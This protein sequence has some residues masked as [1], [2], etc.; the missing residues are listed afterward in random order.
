MHVK[1]VKRNARTVC[2]PIPNYSLAFLIPTYTYMK[3]TGAKM[4]P[5]CS[6][7]ICT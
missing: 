1:N 4:L 6:T 3:I 5:E 7:D 2:G